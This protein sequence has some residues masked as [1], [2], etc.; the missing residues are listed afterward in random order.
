MMESIEVL[1]HNVPETDRMNTFSMTHRPIWLSC[2]LILIW[3][4]SACAASDSAEVAAPLEG[5]ETISLT[6]YRDPT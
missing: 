3:L 2:L 4:A 6:V 5:S 1:I